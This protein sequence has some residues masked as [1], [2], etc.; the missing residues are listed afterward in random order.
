MRTKRLATAELCLLLLFTACTRHTAVVA[1]PPRAPVPA[2]PPASIVALG[3]ADRAFTAKE[4]DDA[5]RAYEDYLRLT[6]SQDQ[7]DQALFRLGMAYTLKKT[8]ADWPRAQAVWKRLVT[9]YPDS[10]LKPPVELILSLYS[11]VG[12]ANI[13]MKARDDR[14]KQLSTELDRLK[15]IDAER[16]K[17]P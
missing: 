12:Q 7:K 5:S 3:E 14:I 10:T 17:T 16:R 6:P 8:G 13:D 9:E 1:A 11:E 15:K 4:Y 2:A